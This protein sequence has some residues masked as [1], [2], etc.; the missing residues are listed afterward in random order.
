M[1]KSKN[2]SSRPSL[3]ILMLFAL[4]VLVA[5]RRYHD[6]AFVAEGD[7]IVITEIPSSSLGQNNPSKT[8][9]V[10][11]ATQTPQI[12]GAREIEYMIVLDGNLLKVL[13]GDQ[14]LLVKR[15]RSLHHLSW[16]PQADE[17]SPPLELGFVDGGCQILDGTVAEL[18]RIYDSGDSKV[19]IE[20]WQWPAP[21]LQIT[22]I[23]SRTL[24]IDDVTPQSKIVVSNSGH[25]LVVETSDVMIW[26][27]ND[28]QDAPILRLPN[29]KFIAFSYAERWLLLQRPDGSSLAFV[30]LENSKGAIGSHTVELSV[31]GQDVSA[32]TSWELDE[33]GRWLFQLDQ[34]GQ[35]W[36]YDL[37]STELATSK[38][39]LGITAFEF[40]DVQFSPPCDLEQP[41][42]QWFAAIYG[43]DQIT[44]WA[45]NDSGRTFSWQSFIAIW[46][47]YFDT[48]GMWLAVIEERDGVLFDLS[49]P[50]TGTIPLVTDMDVRK[51]QA[52]VVSRDGH[53]IAVSGKEKGVVSSRLMIWDASQKNAKPMILGEI[54]EATRV[55]FSQNGAW[56]LVTAVNESYI[57]PL[58]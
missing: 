52:G 4:T 37:T 5:C 33:S 47:L 56:V 57:F 30:S 9:L 35:S 49:Q 21:E 45:L 55:L 12:P 46:K 34:D 48:Q 24:H 19:Q 20:M 36:L 44:L 10:P 27:L 11:T 18:R 17:I 42:V 38:R 26:D 2:R 50:K 54:S 7:K 3:V 51:M 1:P 13:P 14:G 22:P 31:W 16:P 40:Y 29:N 43:Q 15:Y 32:I 25:W 58:P 23:F 28:P 53:W 6:Q 8:A 39:S 41:C